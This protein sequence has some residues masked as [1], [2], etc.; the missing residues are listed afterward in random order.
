MCLRADRA[1]SP[2]LEQPKRDAH[3]ILTEKYI[4]LSKTTLFIFLLSGIKANF[5]YIL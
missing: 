1:G 3:G 4:L 2:W 5:A